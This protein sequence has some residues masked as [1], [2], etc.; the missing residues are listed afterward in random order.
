MGI[1]SHYIHA[2]NGRLRIKIAAVKGSPLEAQEIEDRLGRVHGITYVQANPITGNV[3]IQYDPGQIAQQ[4][5]LQILWSSG[6]VPANHNP[7]QTGGQDGNGIGS[8]LGQALVRTLAHT[9]MELAVLG[10]VRALI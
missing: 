3:L 6:W 8:L 7:V 5:I 10:L 2:L 4:A 1:A 9:T